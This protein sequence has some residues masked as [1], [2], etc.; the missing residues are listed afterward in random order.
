M[1]QGCQGLECE[2]SLELLQVRGTQDINSKIVFSVIIRTCFKG[3]QIC[4]MNNYLEVD[5]K[6]K[7]K[8][9]QVLENRVKW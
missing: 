5:T 4:W 7:M 9:Y 2:A 8:T 6:I 1:D 3:H